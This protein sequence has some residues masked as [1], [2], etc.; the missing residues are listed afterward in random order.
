MKYKCKDYKYCPEDYRDSILL[1]DDMIDFYNKHENHKNNPSS[2]TRLK[3]EQSLHIL[4]Y[5]IK[6]RT[7]EGD[8][9]EEEREE[10]WEYYWGLVY[11]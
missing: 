2:I 1:S 8:L 4:H 5:S 9:S 10:M 6:H 7:V 11:D 3:L